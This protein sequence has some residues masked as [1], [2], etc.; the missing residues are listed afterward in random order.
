MDYFL[1]LRQVDQPSFTLILR[2]DDGTVVH[3][4]APTVDLVDELREGGDVLLAALQGAHGN[5]K[6]KRAV[7]DFA[8]RIINCNTDNFKTTAE[9]LAIRYRLSLSILNAFFD[10]Y[11]DFINDIQNAKN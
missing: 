7:Y 3:L 6:Q 4:C 11:V 10:K 9:E 8:A 2:D 1:D 5:D